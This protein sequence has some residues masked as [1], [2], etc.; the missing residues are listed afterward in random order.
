MAN[1]SGSAKKGIENRLSQRLSALEPVKVFQG[2]QEFEARIQN[3]GL[4][5]FGILSPKSMAPG[6][7]LQLEV[8][9]DGGVQLYEC[10]VVSRKEQ[11]G[12]FLLGLHIQD[13]A[14]EELLQYLRS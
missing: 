2:G 11:Q 10:Q 12:E 14:E 6:D 3:V 9:G 5:G 4:Q 7:K 8:S 13:Q 1:V